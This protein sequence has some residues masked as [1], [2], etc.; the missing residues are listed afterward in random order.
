VVAENSFKAPFDIAFDGYAI[1]FAK[2]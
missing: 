2:E 1:T